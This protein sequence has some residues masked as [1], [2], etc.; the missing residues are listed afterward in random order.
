MRAKEE[1]VGAVGAR[2]CCCMHGL[3]FLLQALLDSALN[4]AMFNTGDGPG[5]QPDPAALKR[6][7]QLLASKYV[8]TKRDLM[9]RTTTYTAQQIV[10]S[11]HDV[12]AAENDQAASSREA[13]VIGSI[14]EPPQVRQ[15]RESAR[16]AGRY[17]AQASR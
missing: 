3:I 15:A 7:I 16:P 17:H 14:G 12:V 13:S 9:V 8:T 2:C 6:R 10:G 4:N 1:K 11:G 5:G